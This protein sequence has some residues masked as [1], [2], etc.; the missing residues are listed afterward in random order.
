LN[1]ASGIKNQPSNIRNQHLPFCLDVIADNTHLI[2]LL[3]AD[4]YAKP[5]W[6][7][8]NL[9]FS[10]SRILFC[11]ALL[12]RC[13]QLSRRVGGR[14]HPRSMCYTSAPGS[15]EIR[16]RQ[17]ADISTVETTV[18]DGIR[19]P[20]NGKNPE[21]PR[22]GERKAAASG[23]GHPRDQTLIARSRRWLKFQA[24][25]ADKTVQVP[26]PLMPRKRGRRQHVRF[27]QRKVFSGGR[28]LQVISDEAMAHSPGGLHG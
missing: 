3:T 17:Y 1:R 5:L 26:A 28:Q 23:P 9:T 8:K 19:A 4:G 11:L 27:H 7:M 14:H 10:A 13:T 16:F 2:R 20:K 12:W 21:R 15:F 24:S 25:F 22:T 18:E 6:F